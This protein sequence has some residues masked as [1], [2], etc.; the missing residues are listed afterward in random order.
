LK[1]NNPDATK[2]RKKRNGKIMKLQIS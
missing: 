1:K 2:S